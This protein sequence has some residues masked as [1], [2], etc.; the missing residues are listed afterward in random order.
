MIR[1]R[2]RTHH[3]DG[4]GAVDYESKVA[5]AQAVEYSADYQMAR[6]AA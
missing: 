1:T 5:L 6:I 4:Y 2:S 3:N